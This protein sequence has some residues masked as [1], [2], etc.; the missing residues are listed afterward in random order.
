MNRQQQHEAVS[1]ANALTARWVKT[2]SGGSVVMAGA[3]AWPL[4]AHLAS[5]A[6]VNRAGFVGDRVMWLG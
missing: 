2:C 5:A 3:G 1:A 6:G 4:L